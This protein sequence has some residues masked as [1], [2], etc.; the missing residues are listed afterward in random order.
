MTL[1]GTP[2]LLN[3]PTPPG[4]P[5]FTRRDFPSVH[6]WRR[7]SD[8][9][10]SQFPDV[11]NLDSASVCSE[12]ESNLSWV[13]DVDDEIRVI[14]NMMVPR[15]TG[16]RTTAATQTDPLS[17]SG[18][19]AREV[20]VETDPTDH[21]MVM[22]E[23][24]HLEGELETLQ[25]E[26]GKL[27]SAKS[28]LK[29]RAAAAEARCQQLVEE[30]ESAV[31]RESSLAEE[32]QA[33]RM[34]SLRYG[35]VVGDY[36]SLVHS[37]DSEAGSLHDEAVQLRQENRELR[38]ML[39]EL[40][41]DLE[42]RCGA[43]EGL[44]KKIAELHV[45][46]QASARARAQLDAE[47][48]SL[49]SQ[50]GV[51]EKA[52]EWFREQLHESQQ[53]RNRLH[54]EHVAAQAEKIVAESAAEALRADKARLVQELADCRQRS[55]RDKEGL[56][57]R[58]EDI[59]ADLLE[60]EATLSREASSAQSVLSPPASA[61]SQD[62]SLKLKLADLEQQ[63]KTAES[64]LLEQKA[65]LERERAEL[66]TEAQRLRLALSESELGRH[67]S[68]EMARE[69]SQKSKRLQGELETAREEAGE[70]RTQKTA[71]E[72]ALAAANEDKRV[73]GESLGALTANLARLEGNFK[74]M[75]TEQVAKA[76]QM[77]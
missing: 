38:T 14:K 6:H 44:K 4:N 5:T 47:N 68:E 45:E 30:K 40:K 11:D 66:A 57:K 8:D 46:G 22:R 72:V 37:K 67:I 63:L 20:A 32:L 59:E 23:K 31:Q 15:R 74:M 75:R 9:L 65:T 21:F 16:D 13:S 42:S 48:A 51:V 64:N 60:R 2:R 33:L 77:E 70:L 41:V 7:P 43:V 50:M 58:L 52:K 76:A 3:P 39:E 19:P 1:N 12:T 69:G 34:E 27:V 55:V 53:G 71:L 10:A 18:G 17:R 29:L 35:R 25:G 26:L 61:S 62:L 49:R 36:D 56:M 24:A 54:R 28:E 73:V